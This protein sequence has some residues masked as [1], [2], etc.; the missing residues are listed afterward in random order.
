MRHAQ[1]FVA[2]GGGT[3]ALGVDIAF[4]L[5]GGVGFGRVHPGGA[6]AGTV[7]LSPAP[8][9]A[10]E[11]EH[12]TRERGPGHADDRKG[13]LLAMTGH[14]PTPRQ[15]PLTRHERLG[16][17]TSWGPA[18]RTEPVIGHHPRPRKVRIHAVGP[19]TVDETPHQRQETL[20]HRAIGRKPG[21]RPE[22]FLGILGR[23]PAVGG[24]I[25]EVVRRSQSPI[26]H[27]FERDDDGGREIVDVDV[28]LVGDLVIQPGGQRRTHDLGQPGPRIGVPEHHRGP[29]H[30]RLGVRMISQP[31]I[32]FVFEGS[33]LVGVAEPRMMRPQRCFLGERYR[34][35]DP[36]SVDDGRR[37]HH[38]TVNTGRGCCLEGSPYQADLVVD[39]RRTVGFAGGE[40]DQH[41]G[42]TKKTGK[43]GRRHVDAMDGEVARLG[44]PGGERQRVKPEHSPI[45][46]VR[47]LGHDAAAERPADPGNG[48]RRWDSHH[49]R[50]LARPTQHGT[51]QAGSRPVDVSAA[52]RSALGVTGHTLAEMSSRPGDDELPPDPFPGD[53]FTADEP[54]SGRNSAPTNEV[55][56]NPFAAMF[57]Q[58]APGA[59]GAALNADVARHLAVWTAAGGTMEAN[60]EPLERIRAETIGVSAT[61]LV[62]EIT[63]LT[64]S[65]G[66]RPGGVMASTKA[67][68]AAD[69]LTAWR[70]ILDG[71]AAGAST[72]LSPSS[73]GDDVDDELTE[74]L[75]ALGLGALPGGFSGLARMLAPTLAGMQAGTLLGQLGSSALGTFDHALPRPAG[76]ALRVVSSAVA[77][78]SSAWTLPPDHALTQV[79]VRDLVSHAVLSLP[80]IAGPITELAT[81]H[82]AAGQVDASGLSSD[83]DLGGLS[84]LL[85]GGM[86]GLAAMMGAGSGSGNGEGSPTADAFLAGEPTAEQLGL[87]SQLRVLTVPV[88]AVIEHFSSAIGA[89]LIGDNRQV[90]EALR[91]RRLERDTGTRLVE[92]LLGVSVD[93]AGLDTGRSFVGGVLERRGHDGLTALFVDGQL[94]TVNELAAPGLWLARIGQDG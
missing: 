47:Q 43:I 15:R 87:R 68:W 82:A 86:A 34:I 69:A 36:R 73:P 67:E 52:G 76:T 56:N 41:A 17:R 45:G 39:R 94:P 89:R 4:H 12:Q 40:V 27:G 63:G 61:E 11:P 9:P 70:P 50:G 30:H 78:F 6:R 51:S 62:E 58:L 84:G 85:G 42:A 77:A 14:E 55:T 57:S 32:D 35:V 46:A 93:Q 22:Q 16:V 81:R 53:P 65:S 20:T 7:Q 59:S 33:L 90:V 26:D 10:D 64:L 25:H 23:Q 71:L 79:I 48:H 31:A 5:S 54:D 24:H 21:R 92:R 60:V 28:L 3:S 88:I 91:R 2:P 18:E 19:V 66:R 29:Q 75:Q 83:G 37:Q 49:A 72:T 13:H 44:H 38:H 1:S 8:P 74:Q 80:H